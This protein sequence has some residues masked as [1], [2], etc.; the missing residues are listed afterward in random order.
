MAVGPERP[1]V[2]VEGYGDSAESLSGPFNWWGNSVSQEVSLP[3]SFELTHYLYDIA[4]FP[5]FVK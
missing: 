1:T 5:T 2:G 4:F 3:M